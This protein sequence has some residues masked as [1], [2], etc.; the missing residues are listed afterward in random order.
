MEK[1]DVILEVQMFWRSPCIAR[2]QIFQIYNT[3]LRISYPKM[4]G[5]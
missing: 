3:I 5:L 4:D 2:L 1:N